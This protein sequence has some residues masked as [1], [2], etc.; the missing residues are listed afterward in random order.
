[1]SSIKEIIRKETLDRISLDEE[2]IGM[3][4]NRFMNMFGVKA[5]F[6]SFDEDL[7]SK[8]LLRK[9]TFKTIDDFHYI[10]EREDEVLIVQDLHTLKTERLISSDLHPKTWEFIFGILDKMNPFSM[11]ESFESFIHSDSF[12]DAVYDW[13][14]TKV[15]EPLL[16][17]LLL[18]SVSKRNW[19]HSFKI[20]VKF[21][22]S[23]HLPLATGNV[24]MGRKLQCLS[25][26]G[27]IQYGYRILLTLDEMDAQNI[28]NHA[29][30]VYLNELWDKR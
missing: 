5:T 15:D 25:E 22:K 4:L 16:I 10:A 2:P 20:L 13:V 24:D 21:T 3:I 26:P 17:N 8:F 7:L 28:V 30:N 19:I 6:E 23:G 1:M 14:H 11:V 18:S 9:L 12:C 27:A 29:N